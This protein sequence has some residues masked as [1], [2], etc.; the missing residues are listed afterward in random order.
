MANRTGKR[1]R[2]GANVVDRS[3]VLGKVMEVLPA[4]GF[5]KASIADLRSA[6]GPG[7]GA[8]RR[9]FGTRD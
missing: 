9:A 6:G 5:A 3:A 8:L 7:Y 2:Q 4:K 1:P